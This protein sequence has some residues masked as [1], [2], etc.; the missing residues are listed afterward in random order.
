MIW[1]LAILEFDLK[2]VC[3]LMFALF[4]YAHIEMWLYIVVAPI[5]PSVGP[6]ST[7]W[8]L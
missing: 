5:C 7:T 8:T 2:S 6:T 3:L 1:K 4:L